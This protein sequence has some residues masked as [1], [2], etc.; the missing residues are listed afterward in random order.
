MREDSWKNLEKFGKLSAKGFLYE[1]SKKKK[2][3]FFVESVVYPF[4]QFKGHKKE[5]FFSMKECVEVLNYVDSNGLS[6]NL[7]IFFVLS[8]F[9]FFFLFD[10]ENIVLWLV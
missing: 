10:M 6:W 3:I 7:S 8:I 9:P 2:K 4:A 5:F 1:L